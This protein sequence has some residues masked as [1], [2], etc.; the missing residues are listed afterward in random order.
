MH[1]YGVVAC[2]VAPPHLLLQ[3]IVLPTCTAMGDSGAAWC[4]P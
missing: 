1:G 3:A 4:E 2:L